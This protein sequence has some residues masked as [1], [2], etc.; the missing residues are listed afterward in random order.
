MKTTF[1]IC[2]AGLCA[3]QALAQ[4]VNH[5]FTFDGVPAGTAVN[6]L[7]QPPTLRLTFDN[8]H[9][10]PRLN[11][12]GFPIPGTERWR[13]DLNAPAVIVDDPSLFGRGQAPSPS[14]ALEA[15]FQPVLLTFRIPLDI[16][17]NGFRTVLDNDTF[18]FNGFLPGFENIAVHFFDPTATLIDR[19][20]VDQTTPGFEVLTGSHANVKWILLPAGAFYDNLRIAGTVIPTPSAAGLIAL[21]GLFALGRHRRDS[22]GT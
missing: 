3:S 4:V 9:F 11:S 5:E 7:S 16:D 12:Q 21:A 15:L 20:Q 17:A 8:A 18:G 10:A 6:S 14:N 13:P 19:V 22:V 2:A 1:L